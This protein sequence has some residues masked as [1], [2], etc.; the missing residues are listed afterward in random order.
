MIRQS[1]ITEALSFATTELAPR[2]E[3]HPQFLKELERTMALLAFEIPNML[4]SPNSASSIPTA[5]NSAGAKTLPE[6]VMPSSIASLL[7]QSQRLK[8][9]AELNA[10]ILTSQSH[11]KDPKLPGMM[12]MLSWGE[13]LLTDKGAEFPR[14]EF[15][16]QAL[17]FITVLTSFVLQ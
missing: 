14:C 10:A 3:E 4:R 15:V 13:S 6:P 7:D 1:K 5:T 17:V 2:G 12:K 16:F 8:T 9:A 11:C